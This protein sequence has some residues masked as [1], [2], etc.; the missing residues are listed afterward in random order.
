MAV[1]HFVLEKGTIIMM[2]GT[3]NGIVGGIVCLNDHFAILAAAAASSHG[4][5]QQIIGQLRTAI[6]TAVQHSITIDNADQCHI[7]KIQALCDHLCSHENIRLMLTKGAQQFF[8]CVLFPCCICIHT[9][10]FRVREFNLYKLLQLLRT[11][12][13][14]TPCITSTFRT[15]IRHWHR[16]SAGMTFQLL[17]ILVI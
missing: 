14:V 17:I 1:F 16:M 2:C 5:L 9:D 11:K 4:L 12:S 6:I 8:M 15:V 3:L 7:F 10:D 13:K